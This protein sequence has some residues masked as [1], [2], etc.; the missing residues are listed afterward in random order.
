[1]ARPHLTAAQR[2]E[3]RK[4]IS[5]AAL[6]LFREGGTAAITI[7]AIAE[8]LEIAPSTIY[9]YFADRSALLRALWIEPVTAFTLELLEIGPAIADPLDRLTTFLQRYAQFAFDNPDIYRGAFMHLS[10]HS[11][12]AMPKQALKDIPFHGL[13][14]RAIRQAQREE[15]FVKGDP[16]LIAQSL[17]AALHGALALPLHLAPLSFAEP[18]ALTERVIAVLLR[19]I[20]T[21]REGRA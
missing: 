10:E 15:R 21:E 16:S 18:A 20:S 5:D 12:P 6:A 7:R 19:G 3:A 14:V 8:R 4:T 9:L 1:M 13:L 17:W 11:Q 2:Q